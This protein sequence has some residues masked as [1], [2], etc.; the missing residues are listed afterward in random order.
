MFSRSELELLTLQQLKILCFRY[1]LGAS[2]N[3]AVKTSYITTLRA[4]PALAIQQLQEGRGL[5]LPTFSSLQNI[6]QA[7][8]E[9][10]TL[11]PQQ[12]ALIKISLEGRRMEVPARYDQERF[13]ALYKAKN[14][15]EQA[16]DN[17][18]MQ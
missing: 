6:G 14:Y 4:F 11:T 10:G 15:L 18:G 12:S 7:L 1:G 13:L 3:P 5:K 16:I 17:L 8:D 9:M 2:G